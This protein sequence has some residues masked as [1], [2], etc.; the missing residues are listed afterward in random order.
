MVSDGCFPMPLSAKEYWLD[1]FLDCRETSKEMAALI[2]ESL[3]DQATDMLDEGGIK[4]YITTETHKTHLI[5]KVYLN[6]RPESVLVEYFI[7]L[8]DGVIHEDMGKLVL[9]TI[10]TLYRDSI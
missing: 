4:Y 1:Y 10:H 5:L 3:M 6:N 7:P 8:I 2:V 9:D